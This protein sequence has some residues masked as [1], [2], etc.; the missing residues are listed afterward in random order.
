[1]FQEHQLNFSSQQL[2]NGFTVVRIIFTNSL[3]TNSLFTYN[4]LTYS[5]LTIDSSQ[6]VSSQTVSSQQS[7]NKQ[8]LHKQ[9]PICLCYENPNVWIRQGFKNKKNKITGIFQFVGKKFK[10]VG[11]VGKKGCF[12]MLFRRVF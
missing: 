10:K 4:L 5:L 12:K 7:L 3:F 8:S 1:M 2:I 11:R 9:S 6:T